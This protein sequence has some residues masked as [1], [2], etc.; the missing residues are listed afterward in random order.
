MSDLLHLIDYYT[1][2]AFYTSVCL[3]VQYT[4]RW[5]QQQQ[6]TTRKLPRS[7]IIIIIY[8]NNYYN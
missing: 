5:K 2:S 1:A 4:L 3:L 6:G 8:Y 7:I